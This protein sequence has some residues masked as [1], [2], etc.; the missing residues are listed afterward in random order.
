MGFSASDPLTLTLDSEFTSEICN[1]LILNPHGHRFQS[2]SSLP[3][4]SAWNWFSVGLS[5][6]VIFSKLLIFLCLLLSLFPWHDALFLLCF[7]GNFFV[8]FFN[9]I[10]FT[11]FGGL[12]L[13]CSPGLF[14]VSSRS[15]LQTRFNPI[16]ARLLSYSMSMGEGRTCYPFKPPQ[17]AKRLFYQ[18]LDNL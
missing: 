3:A 9:C 13:V 8:I 10:N 11:V 5:Q 12:S 17:T 1:L 16:R 14:V 7:F 4:G 18:K 2:S 15:V 6:R